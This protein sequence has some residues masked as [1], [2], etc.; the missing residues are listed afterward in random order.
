MCLPSFPEGRHTGCSGPVQNYISS[1]YFSFFSKFLLLVGWRT[2][3]SNLDH[4]LVLKIGACSQT[5][6]LALILFKKVC[7]LFYLI[8]K[9]I[10]ERVFSGFK[11]NSGKKSPFSYQNPC[12]DHLATKKFVFYS[13]FRFSSDFQ[14]GLFF[15]FLVLK[16]N[17][18]ISLSKSMFLTIFQ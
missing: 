12:F 15:F 7:Y 18:P 8:F 14:Q 9:F 5:V 13:I 4:S 10:S 3:K 1:I 6:R 2:H 11:A 16:Q 17:E